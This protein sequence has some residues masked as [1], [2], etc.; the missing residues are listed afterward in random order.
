MLWCAGYVRSGST[1]EQLNKELYDAPVNSKLDEMFTA[2][3]AGSE[4]SSS[5]SSEDDGLTVEDASSSSISI[6]SGSSSKEHTV[7][8]SKASKVAAFLILG[9]LM[10]ARVLMCGF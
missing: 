2:A 5:S 3:V 6:S 1:F 8:A 4:A 9:L 10:Q 7:V